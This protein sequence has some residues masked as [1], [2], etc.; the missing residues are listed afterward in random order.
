[1][2]GAVEAVLVLG[3]FPS[4]SGLSESLV[5]QVGVREAGLASWGPWKRKGNVL[6][7]N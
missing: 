6:T 5:D 4:P 7:C 3:K 2:H 1:M